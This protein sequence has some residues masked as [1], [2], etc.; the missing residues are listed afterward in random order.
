MGSF[1]SQ[2]VGG[3]QNAVSK[4]Q[5]RSGR[6]LVGARLR[7]LRRERKLTMLTAAEALGVSESKISR[8]ENGHV[9]IRRQDLLDLLALYGVTDPLQQK[10][11]VSLA[12]GRRE[13]A[14]WDVSAVP[15]RD[16]TLWTYEQTADLIRCYQPALVPELLRS[17][18]YARAAHQATH[19]PPPPTAST[20][21]HV[22]NLALRQEAL[23][24]KDDGTPV[25]W[26]AIEEPAL[27]R[28]LG[29]DL[30]TH[31]SQLDAL[32]RATETRSVTIQI[33]PMGSSFVPM[34]RP[35]TIYRSAGQPQ[36]L[37]IHGPVG[38]EIV[39]LPD[40][41]THGRLFEQVV[42]VACPADDTAEVLLQIRER[43]SAF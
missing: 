20:D 22:A 4:D 12:L 2:M 14:W 1:L 41:E 18:E 32:I 31:L 37:A 34:T 43:L 33:N 29:G 40:S 27:W 30:E 21:A 17:Q 6:A 5:E 23:F 25:L 11:L 39:E 13:P 26:A 24:S 35:F 9:P 7:Q 42:C 28:V 16:T 15:L 19:Y 38:D 10:V 36:I 3:Y 8:L